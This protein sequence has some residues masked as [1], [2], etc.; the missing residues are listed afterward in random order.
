MPKIRPKSKSSPKLTQSRSCPNL[1]SL[2]SSLD[3]NLAAK[4]HCYKSTQLKKAPTANLR[5]RSSKTLAQKNRQLSNQV[6]RL[7][8]RYG[9]VSGWGPTCGAVSFLVGQVRCLGRIA[10]VVFR[11]IYRRLSTAESTVQESLGPL[12]CT[13]L[14]A[15]KK[16]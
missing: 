8:T 16:Q 10:D 5:I 4:L 6:P 12:L 3:D 2:D 11:S 1:I 15:L 9:W 13:K 7:C 14:S